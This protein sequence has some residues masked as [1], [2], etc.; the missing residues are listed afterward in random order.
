MNIKDYVL[1]NLIGASAL[2]MFIIFYAVI[3]RPF[4]VIYGM[5]IG[6]WLSTIVLMPS[7]LDKKEVKK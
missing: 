7:I 2:I 1:I 3:D 6:L 5:C 4:L